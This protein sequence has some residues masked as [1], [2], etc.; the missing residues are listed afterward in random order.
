MILLFAA[1]LQAATAQPA[2][3][4]EA[5]FDRCVALARTDPAAARAE[6]VPWG[7]SG[8]AWFARQCAGLAYTQEGNFPAAAVEFEAAAKAAAIASRNASSWTL[9]IIGASSG[10][11]PASMPGSG[12]VDL[13]IAPVCQ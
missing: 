8:G 4:R 6:A 2:D 5:R 12:P 13:K 3:P 7:A 10:V 11:A 9:V 1:A